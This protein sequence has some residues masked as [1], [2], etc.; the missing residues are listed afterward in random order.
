MKNK[1]AFLF[2]ILVLLILKVSAQEDTL[3]WNSTGDSINYTFRKVGIGLS[4]PTVPLHIKGQITTDSLRVLGRIHVGPSSLWLGSILPITGGSDDITSTNSLISFG[5]EPSVTTFDDI[6][7]TIGTQVGQQKLHISDGSS[8]AVRMQYTNSG[9]GTTSS[10]GF[11]IGILGGG[12]NGHAVFNQQ[13]NLPMLFNTNATERMRILGGG[14]IG[15]NTTT[16]N[17]KLEITHGTSGNSGLRFTNLTN[18]SSS[19]TNTTAKILSVDANGDVILVDDQT[20]GGGVN[21]CTSVPNDFLMKKD[22]A[23]NNLCASGVYEVPSGTYINNIGIGSST[24]NNLRSKLNVNGNTKI[25]SGYV[26]TATSAPANGM[27]VEGNTGIGRSNGSGQL[28]EA[29]LHVNTDASFTTFPSATQRNFFLGTASDRS[30]FRDAF[31]MFTSGTNGNET[32]TI[33]AVGRG[34]DGQVEALVST[35]G[36]RLTSAVNGSNA[37]GIEPVNQSNEVLALGGDTIFPN[38]TA[39]GSTCSFTGAIFGDY[40]HHWGRV[41][42]HDIWQSRSTNPRFFRIRPGNARDVNNTDCAMY[43]QTGILYNNASYFRIIGPPTGTGTNNFCQ[44][45]G[46][47]SIVPL[48]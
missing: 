37:P 18:T 16:P 38:T 12:S 17:N 19:I 23:T 5:G 4:N 21:Y 11:Q 45:G 48:F 15:I 2:S 35:T 41:Y 39:T 44:N 27:V 6:Q 43:L 29:R 33:Q 20:G 22:A 28:V 13:E 1:S 3:Q 47:G 31:T 24:S 40:T 9:T 7:F 10:D 14:N 36:V 42:T 46:I 25:G 8:N 30:G 26:A 32:A 34:G